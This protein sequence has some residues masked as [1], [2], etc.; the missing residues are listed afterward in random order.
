M[1]ARKC[2]KKSTGRFGLWR[3]KMAEPIDLQIIEDLEETLRGVESLGS[4]V[5]GR[6]ETRK[7]V[8]PCAGLI[9]V[10][11]I[12]E[13]EADTAHLH[14]LKIVIRIIVEQSDEHA[15]Y[16]LLRAVAEISAAVM[17]DPTRGGLAKHTFVGWSDG[18]NESRH[19]GFIDSEDPF[20]GCDLK[21]T[22]Q[23]ETEEA[24]PT[25]QNFI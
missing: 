3:A 1:S 22:I 10:S 6:P 23:Y 4:V 19:Y 2:R 24:D 21:I 25:E 5:L 7:Q 17:T 8:L 14:V 11:Q 20:A 12:T 18:G 16:V 15:L 9:P 13:L